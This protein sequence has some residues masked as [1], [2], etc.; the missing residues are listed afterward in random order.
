MNTLHVTVPDALH[1]IVAKLAAHD[2]V[3][4]DEFVA[5]V[6]AEKVAT[7]GP[8][9]YDDSPRIVVREGFGTLPSHG[10]LRVSDLPGEGHDHLAPY[11]PA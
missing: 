7:L 9:S 10:I 8:E 6:L 5:E 11:N 2:G 3:S 1:T 4:P